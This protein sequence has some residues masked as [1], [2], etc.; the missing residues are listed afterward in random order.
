MSMVSHVN[1]CLML[2]IRHSA[3]CEGV[4]SVPV[5]PGQGMFSVSL[6]DPRIPAQFCQGSVFL[7][8]FGVVSKLLF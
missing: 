7:R 6:R 5:L 1:L 2:D 3:S 8:F 4:F